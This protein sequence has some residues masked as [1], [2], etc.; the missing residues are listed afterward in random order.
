MGVGFDLTYV[1]SCE[2][3]TQLIKGK[4]IKKSDSVQGGIFVETN[5][6]R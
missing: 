4:N 1:Y 5:Q 6:E 2:I 3:L